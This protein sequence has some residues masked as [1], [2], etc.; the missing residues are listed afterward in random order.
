MSP[1]RGPVVCGGADRARLGVGGERTALR[2]PSKRPRAR[3]TEQYKRGE[4]GDSATPHVGVGR[5]I[6]HNIWGRRKTSR[7]LREARVS[8]APASR[9][10]AYPQPFPQGSTTRGPRL[11]TPEY[12]FDRPPGSPSRGRISRTPWGRQTMVASAATSAPQLSPRRSLR[13]SD[14]ELEPTPGSQTC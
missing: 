14:N 7:P 1:V 2:G 6:N 11:M 13:A 10:A 4:P 5:P 12:R 9:P 8:T 3:R